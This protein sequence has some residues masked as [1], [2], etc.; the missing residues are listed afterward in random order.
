[1]NISQQDKENQLDVTSNNNL[2]TLIQSHHVSGTIMPIIKRTR[3]R[4]FRTAGGVCL[5]MLVV[6]VWSCDAS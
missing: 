6:V 2:L 1:M 4:L 3:T 5:V